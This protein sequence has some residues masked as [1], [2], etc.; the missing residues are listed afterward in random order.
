MIVQRAEKLPHCQ[1]MCVSNVGG[2]EI[3]F[4]SI[5][6]AVSVFPH[7]VDPTLFKICFGFSIVTFLARTGKYK[8]LH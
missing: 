2:R 4:R 5:F 6:F 3:Q 1:E 7:P 8:L